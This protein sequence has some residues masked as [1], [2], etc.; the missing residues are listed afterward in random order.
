MWASVSP[1][2]QQLSQSRRRGRRRSRGDAH[3]ARCHRIRA[4]HLERRSARS[5]R[6]ERGR[7]DG[8][9]FVAAHAS[10]QHV[11]LPHLKLGPYFDNNIPFS[12][13]RRE[14]RTHLLGSFQ[15]TSNGGQRSSYQKTRV[16]R[17]SDMP[18]NGT[19]WRF[20][21]LRLKSWWTPFEVPWKTM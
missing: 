11:A 2:L 20:D 4:F 19:I 9:Q 12:A 13:A 8:G 18:Y 1:C 7:R 14:H 15:G 10:R 16:N 21:H 17:R 3:G 6:A 5:G